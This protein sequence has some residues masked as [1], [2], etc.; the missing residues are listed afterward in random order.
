MR[1]AQARVAVWM[2]GL[3]VGSAIP[4]FYDPVLDR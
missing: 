3:T 2:M 1:T 4:R